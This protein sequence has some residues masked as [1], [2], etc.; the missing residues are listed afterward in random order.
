M[1]AAAEVKELFEEYEAGKTPE[2]LLVKDFDKV[3]EG[4]TVPRAQPLRHQ[5]QPSG[6]RKYCIAHNPRQCSKACDKAWGGQYGGLSAQRL[7]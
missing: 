6:Y 5:A 1:R 2:A 3:R 7:C 4:I